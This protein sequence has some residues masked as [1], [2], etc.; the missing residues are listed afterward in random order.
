MKTLN[1]EQ[2][3]EKVLGLM[4]K[5]NMKAAE[6]ARITGRSEGTISDLI[7]GKKTFTEKLIAVIFDSLS[8]YLGEESLVETRQYTKMWN[9]AKT[10]KAAS[11]FRLVVGNTGIGKS[12]VF[13]KF[14]EENEACWYI[15]ID[16]KGITWNQFL[17]LLAN[18][19][20]VILDK[21]RKRYTSAYLLDKIKE[22]VE[23]N[24]GKNPMLVIDEAEV[25][26]NAFFKDMKNLRT[27]TE[28]L[29]SI[30]IVGITDVMSRIGRIAGL[31]CRAYEAPNG[32]NYKWYPTRENS[33]QYT[34]FARRVS[35]FRIDNIS[36]DDIT[37][38]CTQKG[39]VNK[40]VITLATKRWWNY[41][42]ANR[43]IRR[44]ERMN[45][46]LA[47]ITPEQFEIL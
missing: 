16:R 13:K 4:K 26:S 27:A 36:A 31:E 19:T 23:E 41:D 14:A 44:A 9:I 47:D 40:A 18:K 34:T 8:D 33:N 35:V 29:L 12:V 42:E 37:R 45:I 24:S 25:S 7:S 6:I 10:G 38:F 39:I 2:L 28:G 21:K 5:K 30:V 22:F 15:K 1:Q 3:R 20:G 46:N 11:D 43:A 32:F 17:L